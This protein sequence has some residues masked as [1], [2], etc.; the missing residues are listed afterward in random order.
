M[1]TLSKTKWLQH[2]LDSSV[3]LQ[4]NTCRCDEIK[5]AW[6][7][8]H[9]TMTEHL[10]FLVESGRLRARLDGTKTLVGPGMAVWVPP[11]AERELWGKKLDAPLRY[12]KMRFNLCRRRELTFA[13]VIAVRKQAWDL[14][15]PFQML[16][17]EYGSD[18]PW[19]DHQLRSVLHVLAALFF[20]L[21]DTKATVG[22]LLTPRQKRRIETFISNH[23]NRPLSSADLA[24]TLRLSQDY[25]SRVFVRSYGEPPRSYIKRTR[26]HHAANRLAESSLSVKELADELG[27]NSVHLFCRQFKEVLHV[28]PTQ[29][30]Q[31]L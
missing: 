24:R 16:V 5:Q 13:K 22:T 31:A 23:I 10:V 29:Y 8:P 18:L 28:T 17:S 27:Y 20:R 19:Q 12:Y 2:L 4:I 25:F 26:I 15:L 6:R 30:R 3:D 7:I 11:G 1:A 21:P 9:K 14:L